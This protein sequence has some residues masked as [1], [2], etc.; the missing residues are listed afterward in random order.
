MTAEAAEG[1][2]RGRTRFGV[3]ALLPPLFLGAVLVAAP[4]AGT[5]T[6]AIADQQ[7]A[8][9]VQ[10]PAP[11]GAPADGEGSGTL[12]R[13]DMETTTQLMSVYVAIVALALAVI[14]FVMLWRIVTGVRSAL[15]RRQ[16]RIAQ[17][18]GTMAAALARTTTQET[19]TATPVPSTLVTSA[20]SPGAVLAAT[21]RN[22]RS[23]EPA[24]H[25][26]AHPGWPARSAQ[27]A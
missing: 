5:T 15:H 21:G 13:W 27:R 22:A 1:R 12:L 17:V 19:A 3:A 10:A 11:D 18:A 8:A 25:A 6:V 2:E 7:A 14:V 16:E 26:S 24:P 4:F 9:P 23:P 20:T